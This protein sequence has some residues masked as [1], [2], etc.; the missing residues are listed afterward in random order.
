VLAGVVF[1]QIHTKIRDE[2]RQGGMIP[3]GSIVR[4]RSLGF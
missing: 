4:Q 1:N 3:M 2:I